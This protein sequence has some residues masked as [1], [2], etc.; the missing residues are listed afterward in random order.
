MLQQ[1]ADK[2]EY[3]SGRMPPL[4]VLPGLFAVPAPGARFRPARGRPALLRRIN[5]PPMLGVQSGIHPGKEPVGTLIML[6]LPKSHLGCRERYGHGHGRTTRLF[7][8]PACD[9]VQEFA[10]RVSLERTARPM[11]VRKTV[12]PNRV[13]GS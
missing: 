11:Q 12:A 5:S 1:F 13:A 9:T 6:N 10:G 4:G 3:F 8:R 2:H 7:S